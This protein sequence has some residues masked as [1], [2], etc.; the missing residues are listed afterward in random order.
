MSEIV[1]SAPNGPPACGRVAAW[2][3]CETDFGCWVV[4][5]Q[6]SAAEAPGPPASTRPSA[7][8]ASVW[9]APNPAPGARVKT[10]SVPPSS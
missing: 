10:S 7:F 6:A 3:A 9:A 4:T 1:A 2:T 5:I 8:W